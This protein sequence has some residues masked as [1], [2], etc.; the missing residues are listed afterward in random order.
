MTLP[1]IGVVIEHR[2][3]KIVPASLE[4]LAKA[5]GSGQ[6]TEAW[7]LARDPAVAE[8]TASRGADTVHFVESLQLEQYTPESYALLLR[9]SLGSSPPS[10]LLFGHTATGM[11]LAPKLAG[12]MSRP[13]LSDVLD[14]HLEGEGLWVEK[15]AYNGK[16]LFR[17]GVRCPPPALITLRPATVQALPVGATQGTVLKSPAD[18]T[19][20]GLHRSVL[21]SEEPKTMDIDLADA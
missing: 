8:E 2:G 21:G 12:A 17:L 13:L 9:E 15:S 5:H 1:G 18:L 4:A 20:L 11:E 10:V 3:G 19:R 6:P 16:L 7:V 14:F